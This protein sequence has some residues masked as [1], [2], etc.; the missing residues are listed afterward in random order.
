MLFPHLDGLEFV[1]VEIGDTGVVLVARTVS[2]PVACRECGTPS[3]RVHD[4]YRRSLKDLSCAGRP[5]R[6]ELEVR[7]FR[8]VGPACGVAT[9]VEQV[10]GVTQWRQRRTP[11]LRAVLERVALALAGRAGARLTARLGVAVSRCTLLRLIR[12]LPDP[13]VGPVTVLG[14]D[15]FAKRKGQSYATILVD[16]DTLGSKGRRNTAVQQQV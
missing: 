6:V 4:R 2:G 3:A 7:R 14:V 11:R 10:E 13:E 9:F 1:R 15:E 16:M 5:V 12:A 8:C